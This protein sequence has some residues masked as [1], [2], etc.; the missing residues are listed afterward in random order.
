VR[1][2][3]PASTGNSPITSYTVTSSPGGISATGYGDANPIA[4]DGLSD[5]VSY[6]FTVVATNAVGNSLPSAASNAITP[7]GS[8]A[9]ANDL[10]NNAQVIGRQWQRHRHECQRHYRGR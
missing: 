5:G 10:F 7:S 4:V 8:L 1:V 9:P 2:S 3:A 6:T